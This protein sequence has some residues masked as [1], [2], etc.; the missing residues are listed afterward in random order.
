MYNLKQAPCAW[1][2][3]FKASLYRW[4]FT[5]S[6]FDNSLFYKKIEGKILLLV[7]YVDEHIITGDDTINIA[8]LISNLNH[9]F[10]LKTLGDVNYFLGFEA[11]CTNSYFYLHQRQYTLD[12]LIKTNMIH[13]KPSLAPMCSN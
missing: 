12:L 11:H 6:K 5:N 2:E 8:E 3:S 10:A 13:V 7:I 9:K 4:Q 1:L